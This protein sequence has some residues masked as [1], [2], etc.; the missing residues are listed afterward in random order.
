MH[1]RVEVLK[2]FSADHL[3]FRNYQLWQALFQFWFNAA[4]YLKISEQRWFS[5]HQRWK[6]DFPEQQ[7]QPWTALFQRWFSL[8]HLSTTSIFR[9]L[10]MTFVNSNFNFFRGTVF[11]FS[12][13]IA[14]NKELFRFLTGQRCSTNSIFLAFLCYSSEKTHT[15]QAFESIF[16]FSGMNFRD[17]SRKFEFSL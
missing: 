8:K 3:W 13:Q 6:I 15:V 1:T 14:N 17:S 16:G 12:A 9:G 4:H 2:D 5:S 10:R 7:N 11:S